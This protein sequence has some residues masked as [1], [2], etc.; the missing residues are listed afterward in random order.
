M[1]GNRP[2]ADMLRLRTEMWIKAQIRQCDIRV[3]P[4]V[5]VR[6]GDPDGGAVYLRLDRREEGCELLSRT[7]DANGQRI[8]YGPVGDGPLPPDRVDAYLAKQVDFDPDFWVIEIDDPARRYVPS[9][10]GI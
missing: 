4:A 8:W 9:E 2:T 7:Y 6:R 1:N 3:I 5:I 10:N